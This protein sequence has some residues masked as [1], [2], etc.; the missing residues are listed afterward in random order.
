MEAARK[1]NIQSGE[2]YTHLFPAAEVGT[3]TIRRNAGVTDTV[4][5]IPKVVH[6]TLDHTK[7]LAAMLKGKDTYETCSK[8]WHFVYRHIAYKKDQEGYEQIRSP[9]RAWHDRKTG[10]DCDCYS[11]FISSILTNLGIPHILRI[12][13]Y[14]RD[15]FQHIYPVVPYQG[16][17]ITI[18]CVT[19]QFDYEVPYSEKKDYPMDLQ[20]LNGF[21]SDDM[22]EL[23]KLF[24]RRMGAAAKNKRG[25]SGPKPKKPKKKG[26]FKKLISKVNKFNPATILLRNGVLAS[27]KLN[28]KNVAKR[29]RWSYLTQEQAVAKGIDPA[30]FQRLVATR[31]KLERIFSGAGGKVANLKK[32]ILR[33]KG[34]RD[35]AVAGLG[36][37]PIYG[38]EYMDTATPLP[39]LLGPEIY[40]SENVE[41]FEGLGELGEP[42]T[43]ASVAAAAGVISGIVAALKQIG[44]VFKKKSKDS[45]D[46]DP[47]RNEAAES[48]AP[49]PDT[50]PVPPVESTGLPPAGSA[51][52]DEGF[53]KGG[54]G[55]SSYAMTRTGGSGDDG[56]GN[57]PAPVAPVEPPAQIDDASP[58]AAAVAPPTD[59]PPPPQKEGF[60]DKNKSWLKPVAIGVGGIG[61]IAIGYA[62]FKPKHPPTAP[63]SKPKT[64]GGLSGIPKKK[65][66]NHHRSNKP[67]QKKKKVVALI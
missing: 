10:V 18:D 49:V 56:G 9:A 16:G 3:R 7:R 28:I 5:F 31:E 24:A 45:E 33:G 42:I 51:A 41:G 46:F 6:Q 30:K 60:W 44:D 37:L 22:G 19:D 36:E 11:V 23:G 67:H 57:F 1:R 29:L 12:T 15:Y 65:R 54:G 55:G 48:G 35:K 8:I 2:G 26:F 50:T 53:V 13:K 17:T 58:P 38:I 47:A 25:S 20:Y 43:L 32:A 4:A 52:A 61:L 66:K 62:V 39:Q 40:H 64:G 59:P 63:A 27:M 34:N 21:E 14:H